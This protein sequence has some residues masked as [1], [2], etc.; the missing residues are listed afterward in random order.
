MMGQNSSSES[1]SGPSRANNDN[2]RDTMVIVLYA[3]SACGFASG[4]A[5]VVVWGPTAA[6]VP[7]AVGGAASATAELVKNSENYP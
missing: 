5:A 3:A 7:T 2:G 1:M 6:V 4:A